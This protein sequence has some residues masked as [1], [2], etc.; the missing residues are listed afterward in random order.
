VNTSEKMK[1]LGWG[2]IVET[3]MTIH[4]VPFTTNPQEVV[5]TEEE[6]ET[7]RDGFDAWMERQT[8]TLQL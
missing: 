3:T 6:L 4:D 8:G 7:L 1:E 2:G 5:P